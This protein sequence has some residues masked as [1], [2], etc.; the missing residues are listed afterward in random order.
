MLR[1]FQIQRHEQR[2][3]PLIYTTCPK[4]ANTQKY[5][6]ILFRWKCS[7]K[8]KFC[9]YQLNTSKSSN[10]KGVYDVEIWQVQVEEECIL[11]LIPAWHKADKWEA[12]RGV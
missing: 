6:D 5:I 1:N 7:S 3:L 9:I 2:L 10:S 8:I 4:I 12:F 11:C